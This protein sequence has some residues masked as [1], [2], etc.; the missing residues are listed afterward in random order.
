M[1]VLSNGTNF[2]I[3]TIVINGSLAAEMPALAWAHGGTPHAIIQS[4]KPLSK[5]QIMCTA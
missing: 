1:L 3:A 4:F 5:L 2:Q